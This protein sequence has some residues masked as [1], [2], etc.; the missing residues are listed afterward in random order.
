MLKNHK[1]TNCMWDLLP[2]AKQGAVTLVK[3]RC[4]LQT[5]VNSVAKN[6]AHLT[7]KSLSTKHLSVGEGAEFV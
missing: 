2:S 5:K 4:D 1:E 7:Q 3:F 6:E